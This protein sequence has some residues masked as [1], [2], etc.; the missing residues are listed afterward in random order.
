MADSNK[1][2]LLSGWP[3]S[4]LHQTHRCLALTAT[5]RFC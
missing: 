4:G 5:A 1:K 3:R 2:I